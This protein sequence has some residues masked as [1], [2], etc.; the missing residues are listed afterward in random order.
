MTYVC[1]IN[2]NNIINI[3]VIVIIIYSE[4][5]DNI[6]NEMIMKIIIVV[7][8]VKIITYDG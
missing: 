5:I 4:N 7:L 8:K 3:N 6:I 1:I 2:N